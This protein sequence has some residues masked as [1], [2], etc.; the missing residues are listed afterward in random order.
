[1]TPPLNKPASYLLALVLLAGCAGGHSGLGRADGMP[2]DVNRYL[3]DRA[4]CGSYSEPS[5]FDDDGFGFGGNQ[6]AL[7]CGGSEGELKRLREKYA[8]RNDVQQALDRLERQLEE[9]PR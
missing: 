6:S 4:A 5:F 2:S 1:M 7:F 3:K 8:G 9:S